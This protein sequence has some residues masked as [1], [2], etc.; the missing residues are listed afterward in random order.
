MPG[1]R[2]RSSVGRYWKGERRGARVGWGWPQGQ[3]GRRGS[4]AAAGLGSLAGR[5]AP[6]AKCLCACSRVWAAETAHGCSGARA[7]R[8]RTAGYQRP[9]FPSR[10]L[11][12]LRESDRRAGRLGLVPVRSLLRLQLWLHRPAPHPWDNIRRPWPAFHREGVG[13]RRV[14]PTAGSRTLRSASLWPWCRKPSCVTSP[15]FIWL[16][17]WAPLEGKP[18]LGVTCWCQSLGN[19]SFKKALVPVTG[20]STQCRGVP[21]CG[22]GGSRA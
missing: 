11:P 19:L 16:D 15:S 5:W 21:A 1:S 18:A 20:Y 8:S 9:L 3:V 17:S 22:K 13:V 14:E 2:R 7:S 4:R 10:Q 12:R 6:G